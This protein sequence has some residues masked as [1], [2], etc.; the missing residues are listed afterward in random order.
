MSGRTFIFREDWFD[1]L[2]NLSEKQQEHVVHAVWCYAFCLDMP[3]LSQIEGVAFNCIKGSVDRDMAKFEERRRKNQENGRKGG[4]PRSE[5][6]EKNPKKPNGFEK[7]QMVSAE[8]QMVSEEK[9]WVSNP[10]PIPI[11]SSANIKSTTAF[12]PPSLSSPQVDEE[13]EKIIYKFFFDNMA[14]PEAEY[15]R[16]MEFNNSDG[17]EWEKMGSERKMQAL[18][19]W[20]QKPK[21]DPRFSKEFLAMWKNVYGKLKEL[22]APEAVLMSALCD[23]LDVKCSADAMFIFCKVELWEYIEENLDE[24]KPIIIPYMRSKKC[25]NLKYNIIE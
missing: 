14:S 24:I 17:R 21:K 1:F 8:N 20:K 22:G 3:Q 11:S 23:G 2:G 6:A 7:N 4:R 19:S 10:I 15:A 13:K 9:R 25:E 12:F 5:N 18:E 16:F